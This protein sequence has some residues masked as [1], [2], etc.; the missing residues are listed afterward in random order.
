MDSKKVIKDFVNKENQKIGIKVL[1]EKS[2]DFLSGKI[3]QEEMA[4]FGDL[5][6]VK[7]Y[8]PI[9]D[10]MRIIMSIVNQQMY[11]DVET[12][13]VKMV[14]LYKN[15]FFYIVL[16]EYGGIDCH[17]REYITYTN[18]DLLY[19]IFAPFI[20]SYCKE[21]YDMIVSMLKDTITLY[22]SQGVL[23]N[24]KDIN[25]ESLKQNTESNNALIESLK[26]NKK[27]INDLKEISIMNDPNTKKLVNEINK[28]VLEGQKTIE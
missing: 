10:K 23:D 6:N 15:I 11:S 20:L 25:M 28:A 16:Q 5:I 13:E 21:D 17:D 1:I 9:L 8:I 4:E 14:E 12:Q 7:S 22:Q 18:Y 26:S 24:L 19:P 3:T 2:K 27:L